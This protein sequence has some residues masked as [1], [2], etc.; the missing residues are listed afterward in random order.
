MQLVTRPQD[1]EAAIACLKACGQE[2][3]NLIGTTFVAKA[4]GDSWRIKLHG[5]LPDGSQG[6]VEHIDVFQCFPVKLGF[7]CGIRQERHEEGHKITRQ[8]RIELRSIDAFTDLVGKVLFTPRYNEHEITCPRPLYLA[9]IPQELR[10]RP[11]YFMTGKNIF[12]AYDPE[13]TKVRENEPLPAVETCLIFAAN[14]SN[15]I[16][17][18]TPQPAIQRSLARVMALWDRM[19]RRHIPS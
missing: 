13:Q 3:R 15:W 10:I 19:L 5:T 2:V 14:N 1:R 9:D 18:V 7:T 12:V 4:K 17:T 11:P 6:T 8:T 16:H